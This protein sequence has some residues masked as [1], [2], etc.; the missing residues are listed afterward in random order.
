MTF[1]EFLAIISLT[2]S[3]DDPAAF[4][5]VEFLSVPENLKAQPFYMGNDR[6]HKTD[7]VAHVA[8]VD[9]KITTTALLLKDAI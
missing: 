5:V 3:F 4:C 6:Y 8:G 1:D 7:L 9:N 2:A